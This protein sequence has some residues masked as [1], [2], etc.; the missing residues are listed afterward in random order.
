MVTDAE[1]A[2]RIDRTLALLKKRFVLA[3]TIPDPDRRVRYRNYIREQIEFHQV[4]R[5]MHDKSGPELVAAGIV[6]SMREYKAM[7][8]DKLPRLCIVYDH[9]KDSF[10]RMEDGD[11]D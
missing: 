6:M 9:E 4:L 2:V 11:H 8:K 10:F 3:E 1:N 5:A 7:P